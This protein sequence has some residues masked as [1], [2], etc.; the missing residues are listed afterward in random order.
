MSFPK[1]FAYGYTI[2][3]KNLDDY[4]FAIGLLPSGTNVLRKNPAYAASIF[5][6]T[7][8]VNFFASGQFDIND[9][10]ASNLKICMVSNN[11]ASGYSVY[12]FT[13]PGGIIGYEGNVNNQTLDWDVDSFDIPP[14][15][16]GGFNWSGLTAYWTGNF[17][18]LPSQPVVTTPTQAPV[19]PRRWIMG[20]EFPTGGEGI[21]QNTRISRD[22]SRTSDGLGW[23]LRNDTNANIQ[24]AV[25]QYRSGFTTRSSWERFYVRVRNFGVAKIDIWKTLSSPSLTN[26]IKLYINPDGSIACYNV[27]AFAVETLLGTSAAGTL[28]ANTWAKLD[29]LP[30]YN[31]L[32]GTGSGAF[33][34]LVNS[35]LVF[36]FS[37]PFASGGVGDSNSFHTQTILGTVTVV[38]NAWEIDFDDW[39]NADIPNVS[40]TITLNSLDWILGTHISKALVVSGTT[41]GWTGVVQSM[42]QMINPSNISTASKFVS[43]TSQAILE[44]LTDVTDLQTGVGFAIA[45][46]SAVICAYSVL[47]SGTVSG[48][49]GYKLAGATTAV[50]TTVS[51]SV[52]AAERT[53]MYLGTGTDIIPTDIVPFSILYR[54]GA[55]AVQATV[56][57]LQAAVEYIG[58]WDSIDNLSTVI[59]IQ[60]PIHNGYYPFLS[61]LPIVPPSLGFVAS[62]GG[63]YV[64]NG[65]T[66]TFTL[67]YPVHFLWI[68][69][70][71]GGTGGVK[72]F[73]TNFGGHLSTNN[74]VVPDYLIKV[75]SN[76]ITLNSIVTIVG[77]DAN[78]NANGVTYQYVAFCDPSMQFNI[79]GAFMHSSLNASATDVLYNPNFTPVAGFFGSD[80]LGTGTNIDLAY[81]GPGAPS[82]L[83]TRMNGTGTVL[84]NFITFGTG[85]ITSGA[86]AH[87]TGA[88]NQVAYSIWRTSNDCLG[89]MVQIFSYTG[90]G[91]SS[92]VITST[93][94]TGKFPL[95]VF[96]QPR[97]GHVGFTRDPSDTGS[98]S[99]QVTGGSVSTTAITAGG[100][101][102][103][104]VGATLNVLNTVYDVFILPGSA[105]SWANGIFFMDICTPYSPVVTPVPFVPVPYIFGNGGLELG[106]TI[107]ITLLKD[108]SG[109][110]TLVPG[111]TADTLYDRQTGQ[112]SID[113]AIPDPEFKTGYIGGE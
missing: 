52:T 27:N 83:A 89:V 33:D 57:G 21:Q 65:T 25:N 30:Q 50:F 47:A 86:N 17:Y 74:S 62:K 20:F 78:I 12:P 95:L 11:A 75:D 77:T 88:S 58:G 28:T 81:K 59:P 63:T 90:D 39:I 23:G 97:D 9:F 109:I 68:R 35:V 45:Q 99:R 106:E 54:K 26:G 42:N 102:S 72:W 14:V 112:T 101:D 94:Q 34:L 8:G 61:V 100:K 32:T 22:S 70:L 43:S 76:V 80:L 15:T 87:P 2:V 10:N 3:F 67:P 105:T 16:S 1:Q 104:T 7:L 51:E 113:V 107:P 55:S 69:P 40:G 36:A 71:T 37:V 18:H 49:L 48:S 24:R 56:N 110:Y 91:T 13:T 44:G 6:L 5:G 4:N 41:T 53:V 103:I 98:N 46:A 31:P 85:S 64:G 19:P 111:K 29:C 108:V 92:R 82:A 66:T 60:L 93:P 73:A 84:T 79:C 96:V 38:A